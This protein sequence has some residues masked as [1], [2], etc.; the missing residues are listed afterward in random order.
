[1]ARKARTVVSPLGVRLPPAETD[2]LRWSSAAP[3]AP[4]PSAPYAYF[5]NNA[6][7]FNKTVMG[8]R[9]A[10]VSVADTPIRNLWPSR[11]TS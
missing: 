1:M 3:A 10:A 9:A 5:F 2:F 4:T 11:L 6:C 8:G 7:Q